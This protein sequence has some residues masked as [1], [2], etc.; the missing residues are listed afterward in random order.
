[1]YSKTPDSNLS[2]NPLAP[3]NQGD[4]MSCTNIERAQLAKLGEKLTTNTQKP[5]WKNAPEWANWLAQDEDGPWYW[6]QSKPEPMKR[7][8]FF[9]PSE[10]L[11]EGYQC[12]LA[13]RGEF[14]AQW[15]TTREARPEVVQ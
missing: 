8:G 9:S 12:K 14:N 13:K 1:M 15:V 10:D 4:I 5:D 11:V 2:I 3:N 6:F 7:E